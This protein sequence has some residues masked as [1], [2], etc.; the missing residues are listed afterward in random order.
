MQAWLNSS[1]IV[2][3]LNI[4]LRYFVS[5]LIL[6]SKGGLMLVK[7]CARA[8]IDANCCLQ[9]KS[10]LMLVKICARIA[11]DANSSRSVRVICK[12]SD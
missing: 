11:I 1:I 9:S 4:F 5:E 2:F 12:L 7:N 8:A 3:H 10:G 6:Q